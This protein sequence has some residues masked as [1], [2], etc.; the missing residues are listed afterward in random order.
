MSLIAHKEKALLVAALEGILCPQCGH[1]LAR[2]VDEYGC[3]Y[4]RGDG[5][6]GD[7]EYLQALGPCGCKAEEH[8]EIVQAIQALRECQ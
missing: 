1:T 5:Y 4:D 2:H 6:R 7:A 3:E 8:P